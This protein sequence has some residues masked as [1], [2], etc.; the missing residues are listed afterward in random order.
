P[1]QPSRPSPPQR[2]PPFPGESHRPNSLPPSSRCSPSLHHATQ[3][4]LSLFCCTNT[5]E[6]R[7]DGHVDIVINLSELDPGR[8]GPRAA[9]VLDAVVVSSH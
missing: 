6:I 1:P 2:A 3:R 7:G 8:P 9:V 5:S 4:A